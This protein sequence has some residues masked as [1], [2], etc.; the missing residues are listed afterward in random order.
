MKSE[1][2]SLSVPCS[3]AEGGAHA[4]VKK[5]EAAYEDF[6]IQDALDAALAISN[7][8]NLYMEEVAPWSA[9]KKV[10]LLR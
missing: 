9:F 7:R 3:P 2:G 8:G 1:H 6:R 5:A 4:Q 10:Q